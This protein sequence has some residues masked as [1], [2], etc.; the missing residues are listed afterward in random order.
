[1]IIDLEG[2]SLTPE[3][4]EILEHPSVAGVILFTRNYEEPD[5]LRALTQQIK[6]RRPSLF[7]AV[8]HEGGRVQRFQEGFT[9]IPSMGHFGEIYLQDTQR[10]K[11]ELQQI[12]RKAAAELKAVGIDLNLI[13]VLDINHGVSEVIG[14]RSFNEDPHTVT[15]LARVVIEALHAEQMP[16]MGKHFPG[17]GGVSADSHHE[18][19]VDPRDPETI[20]RWDLLPFK[21]LCHTLDA[22]MPAHVVYSAFDSKPAGFSRF[23]LQDVLREQLG[24]KG[25]VISD[26]L[27]MVG[28]GVMGDYIDRAVHALEAGCDLIA[29]CN[30]RRGAITVI[31][32]LASYKNSLSK[33]RI[34]EFLSKMQRIR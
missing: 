27:T 31:E 9:R 21:Q 10:A 34:T 14:T 4:R 23:W 12:V 8:D 24:F 22:I 30:N 20:Q 32:G 18:L 16:A 28:A 11:L 19:P 17:H 7:I 33:E 25:V 29:V 3:E 13:P 6:K 15:E 26:D 5:Q 2:V 1:M